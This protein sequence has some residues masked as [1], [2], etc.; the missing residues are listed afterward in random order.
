MNRTDRLYALAESL[1]ASAPRPLRA[2]D[3][4]RRFEVSTR[5]IERDLL[6]LQEAG[7][8]IWARPGPTGGYGLDRDATLPPPNLSAAEL[9][10][11]ATAV[12]AAGPSPF[13]GAARAA[14]VRLADGAAAAPR[15]GAVDLVA[16][17]RVAGV[18][19]DPADGVAGVLRRAMGDGV[20][21]A[22]TYRD[23]QGRD[24]EREVEPGGFFATANGWYLAAWCRLR[25][26]P[27]AFRLDR[28]VRAAATTDPA[29]PRSLDDLLAELPHAFAEPVVP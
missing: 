23:G 7:L 15:A 21:V 10:A 14:L 24:S 5:T 19:G 9:A 4:A 28:I 11:L 12:A 3:L 16:R 8:P 27:R 13:A 18:P 25:G 22:L 6:A 17:V 20:A 1:R 26:A 2:A 29:M